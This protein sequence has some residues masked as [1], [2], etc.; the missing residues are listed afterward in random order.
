M[1]MEKESEKGME[2]ERKLDGE[3]EREMEKKKE[4]KRGKEM[5]QKWKNESDRIW[6]KAAGFDPVARN[7]ED[8]PIKPVVQHDLFVSNVN[9]TM[10]IAQFGGSHFI[11]LHE[12]RL[13]PRVSSKLFVGMTLFP[14]GSVSSCDGAKLAAFVNCRLNVKL[15][16]GPSLVSRMS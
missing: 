4:I 10:R 7:E 8:G 5:K 15:E 11:R 2:M 6:S 9:E 1:E 3:S 12:S 14:L 16:S 13:S